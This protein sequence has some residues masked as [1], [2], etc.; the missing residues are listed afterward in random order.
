MGNDIRLNLL[1]KFTTRRKRFGYDDVKSL[2]K[3]EYEGKL[4]ERANV[5]TWTNFG[6]NYFIDFDQV[7][8]TLRNGLCCTVPLGSFIPLKKLYLLIDQNKGCWNGITRDMIRPDIF[9]PDKSTIE[10]RIQSL[11]DTSVKLLDTRLEAAD[12]ET[13]KY[14]IE[15][16]TR[17]LDTI[18]GESAETP[19]VD[20]FRRQIDSFRTNNYAN[21][22]F[23]PPG[24]EDD[25]FEVVRNRRLHN[26]LKP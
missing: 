19:F 12:K 4:K 8:D 15:N 13:V 24:N 1:D 11:I 9:E 3:E 16:L 20:L 17:R 14:T 6:E 26:N 10:K 18:K 7:A 2:S 25:L 5:G 22:T 21:C 23:I